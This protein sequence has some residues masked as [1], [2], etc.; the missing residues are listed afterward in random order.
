VV[1][2]PQ[3]PIRDAQVDRERR[4]KLIEDGTEQSPKPETLENSRSSGSVGIEQ[5]FHVRQETAG[6]HGEQKR[7]R[8]LSAQLVNVDRSGSR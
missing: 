1:S 4:R 2:A 8:N 7:R 6:L 3:E 5:S